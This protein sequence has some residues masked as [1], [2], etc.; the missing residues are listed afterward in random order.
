[1]DMCDAWRL[2]VFDHPAL[3]RAKQSII[4]RQNFIK[5]PKMFIQRRVPAEG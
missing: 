4:K 2:Q 3:E 5:R 1:M